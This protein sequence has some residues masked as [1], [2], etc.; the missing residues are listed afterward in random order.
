HHGKRYSPVDCLAQRWTQEGAEHVPGVWRRFQQSN[1]GQYWIQHSD[2]SA[3]EVTTAASDAGRGRSRV[4]FFSA[5]ICFRFSKELDPQ[6]GA[7][8]GVTSGKQGTGI[9]GS[10][11]AF[12]S[13]GFEIKGRSTK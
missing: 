1:H 13:R 9:S 11:W 4:P 7:R 10:C 5:H 2:R 3:F 12:A 8:G 6:G